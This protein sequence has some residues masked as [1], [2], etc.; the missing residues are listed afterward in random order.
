MVAVTLSPSRFRPNPFAKSSIEPAEGMEALEQLLGADHEQLAFMKVTEEPAS[1]F[2]I[3]AETL[4]QA[5]ASAPSLSR[6]IRD[7][8]MQ[9]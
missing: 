2:S 4:M 1:G 3:A 8:E 6:A 7:R 5:K 9:V